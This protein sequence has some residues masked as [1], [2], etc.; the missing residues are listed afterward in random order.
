M[1]DV[2][3]REMLGK[4]FRGFPISFFA[5]IC[6]SLVFSKENILKMYMCTHI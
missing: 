6:E 1:Q 3:M 5:T 2:N 4:G